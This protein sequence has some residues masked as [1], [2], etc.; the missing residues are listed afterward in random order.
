MSRRWL[1][2]GI[3]TLIVILAILLRDVVEEVVIIPAAYLWW[4]FKIYYAALPQV[5]FWVALAAVAFYSSISNLIP[6]ED[7]RAIQKIAPAPA[8]GHVET[9]A[10]I[11][12]KS[13]RGM[14]YRW[15]VAN[16][17]GKDARE[18][19]AQ[20][21]GHPVS[22][23]FGGLNHTRGWNPPKEIDAYLEV[24]LLGSFASYPRQ[25]RF[26][27]EPLPTPLDV[28]IQQVMEYLED[29]MEIT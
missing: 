27:K 20:R 22:K 14:Y 5:V 10:D 13:E 29:E 26:W 21:E 9:L 3:F 11:I 8:R 12:K 15:L 25:R 7:L 23:N 16:R 6:K 28:D 1:L 17:L 2:A 4:L 19:I 18:I 24:G